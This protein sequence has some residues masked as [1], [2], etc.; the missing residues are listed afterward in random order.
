MGRMLQRSWRRAG[1]LTAAPSL[2][3]PYATPKGMASTGENL[4]K[5]GRKAAADHTLV[6][7]MLGLATNLRQ[8]P[9][10][11]SPPAISAECHDFLE[12]C[13]NEDPNKRATSA[14]LL[15]HPWIAAAVQATVRA[16]CPRVHVRAP[17]LHGGPFAGCCRAANGGTGR[18]PDRSNPPGAGRYTGAA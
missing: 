4:E 10:G 8:R 18:G 12:R 1:A 14:T 13:F 9:A 17:D 6:P 15:Q 3:Y 7:Y 16:A 2:S 11:A 5:L